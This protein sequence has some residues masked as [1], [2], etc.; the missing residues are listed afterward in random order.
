MH[1]HCLRNPGNI[2]KA[3]ALAEAMATSILKS[4]LTQRSQTTIPKAV[5]NALHLDAGGELGYIIEGNQVRLV[6]VNEETHED[7]LI[8][9]FLDFLAKDLR[10][11]P[12][13]VSPFPVS[14][15]TRMKALSKRVKIDHQADIDGETAL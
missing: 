12:Q 9:R 2:T 11:H 14:L 10:T 3:F 5:K 15:V 13:H 7:P 1:L 8:G 4:K 6:N